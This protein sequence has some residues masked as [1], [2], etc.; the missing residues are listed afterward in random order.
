MKK[1]IELIDLKLR[2]KSEQKEILKCLDKVLSKGHLILTKEL[3]DFEKKISNYNGVKYCLGLNS[4]T[5]S[6]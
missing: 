5:G 1:N 4:G 6:V 3:E 2:Y